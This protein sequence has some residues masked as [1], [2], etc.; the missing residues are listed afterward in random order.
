MNSS[1]THGFPTPLEF[2]FHIVTNNVTS[3]LTFKE[4]GVTNSL[5]KGGIKMSEKSIR[6]ITEEWLATQ[7]R[8]DEIDLKGY[9]VLVFG[10]KDDDGKEISCDTAIDII[11]NDSELRQ[12]A[13]SSFRQYLLK[14]GV[15]TSQEYPF[16]KGQDSYPL[17]TNTNNLRV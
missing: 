3:L 9:L 15:V 2:E 8:R 6:D 17:Y 11:T 12:S 4:K 1:E 7:P 13:I 5:S 16:G 10:I 14:A